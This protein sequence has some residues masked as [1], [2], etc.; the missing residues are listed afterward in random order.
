MPATSKATPG[1]GQINVGAP[2]PGG[3]PLPGL[4]PQTG[5]VAQLR[6]LPIDLIDPDPGQARHI[7]PEAI[8]ARFHAHQLSAAQAITE[9]VRLAKQE[10]LEAEQLGEIAALAES[11]VL[12]GGVKPL[13]VIPAGERYRIETGERRFWGHQYAVHVLGKSERNL[14]EAMVRRDARRARQ[15]VE[16]LFAESLTAVA[17]GRMIAQLLLEKDQLQMTDP[18]RF[19]AGGSTTQDLTA[20]EYRELAGARVKRGG[21]DV[22]AA[23][24]GKKADILQN[25]VRLLTL[26]DEVQVLADRGRLSE[27]AL[28]A[29]LKMAD[30][31]LQLRVTRFAAE[32]KLTAG[33]VQA[34]AQADDLDA[35]EAAVLQQEGGDSDGAVPA[36]PGKAAKAEAPRAERAAVNVLWGRVRALRQ[37]RERMLKGKQNPTRALASELAKQGKDAEVEIKETVDFLQAVLREL[38]TKKR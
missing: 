4:M 22:L 20:A 2:L 35:A 15:A 27:K 34:L 12:E 18:G 6:R 9:W 13:T 26:P 36:Q 8:R 17:F 23:L 5:D 1:R 24:T 14:V 3:K 37:Y 31:K 25:H 21:W 7:L 29:V 11:L 16:N 30:P 28:R 32:H 19:S 38:K 10:P 33:Q